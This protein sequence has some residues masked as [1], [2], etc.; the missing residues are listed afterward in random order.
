MVLGTK[1]KKSMTESEKK[2]LAD[3]VEQRSLA[4]A[5]ILCA[6]RLR[7]GKLIEDMENNYLQGNNKYPTTVSSAYHLLS[8]WKQDP[9]HGRREVGGGE[10]SFVNN[11]DKKGKAR[12]KKD[13]TCHR[14]KQ[15]GHYANTCE[16]E[17][18]T[19]ETAP[20]NKSEGKTQSGTTL[21]T[22]ENLDTFLD[23]QED[24]VSYQFINVGG[25]TDTSG[26]VMH[27]GS[28]GRLPRDWILLDNQ[29][30][31]DVFCNKNLLVNIREHA[32]VMDIH[33]NAGVTSTKLVGDLLGYGTV[34][35]HPNGIANIL[36][37]ARV[38][39]H[40]YRVTFDTSDGNAFHIH[41]ADGTVRVFNQSPKG[42]Y[43]MDTKKH[44]EGMTMINTVEDNST[45]YSQR[46]Y[47]KAILA[48][49]IQKIIGRPSTKT[50]LSIVEK[51]LLPNCP[52]TRD[53]IIAA[54][55]ILGPEV[56][57]LKGKTVRKASTTV[58]AVTLDVPM[59]IMSR[60]Q[61]V[62]V[63]GDIMYVNKLPFFVTISRHIKFS[64]AEF[65]SNQKTPT[66]VI[67]IKH[68][69]QMY[70]KRGFQVTTLLMDGQF[71]K[72]NLD[73]EIAA[74]GITLNVVA[75]DE[76]VPEVERHIRTIKERSRSVINMVPFER[77]PARMIIELIYYC[78]FWLNSFPA[79]GG[80]SDIL[81]PRAIVGIYH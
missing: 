49:K 12:D 50:F 55:R 70:A 81:S 3:D 24:Y 20:E 22:L 6:D 53:D 38:K 26:V 21:L 73:G 11:G 7:F 40:G 74:F 62:T 2:A 8:N 43:Y 27:I 9:R 71:N 29:S 41:K 79:V 72:D 4:V 17:R 75:A 28:D 35:Y 56:G 1:D 18:V 16:N 25:L 57:S 32:D 45:K 39:E 64:T 76:H 34:W 44:Q 77:Y 14:C 42:L 68:L 78:G 15:K 37:L 60:Y 58:E 36:S 23:D 63:T 47:S 13:V 46:D 33:C 52:V 65:L 59:S 10:I 69:H 30:T 61:K 54:E 67:A 5:F 66:I 51:N 48:R 80:I 19:G 31:V